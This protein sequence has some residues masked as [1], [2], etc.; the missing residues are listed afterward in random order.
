MKGLA[1][2]DQEEPGRGLQPHREPASRRVA[3]SGAP[4]EEPPRDPARLLSSAAPAASSTSHEAWRFRS[5]PA[6]VSSA[7]RNPDR[8]QSLFTPRVK[9]FLVGR[10]TGCYRH[11]RRRSKSSGWT[12]CRNEPPAS[13]QPISRGARLVRRDQYGNQFSAFC[14]FD[15]TARLHECEIARCVLPKLSYANA[16]HRLNVARLVLHSRV[17]RIPLRRG[18]QYPE[19]YVEGTRPDLG[20]FNSARGQVCCDTRWARNEIIPRIADSDDLISSCATN[21]SR[22]GWS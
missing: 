16:F 7:P 6:P 18:N 11:R 14:H 8:S 13:D 5:P 2:R 19:R 15:A 17:I 10:L 22:Y 4:R 1:P 3:R 9:Q 20:R 21:T 12:R